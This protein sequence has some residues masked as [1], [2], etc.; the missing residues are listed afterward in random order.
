M[1]DIKKL[2]TII[3][4]ALLFTSSYSS[5]AAQAQ[6]QED[7]TFPAAMDRIDSEYGEL[8]VDPYTGQIQ[9]DDDC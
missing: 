7:D 3:M 4:A 1:T 9:H 2:V 5:W 8:L 6:A